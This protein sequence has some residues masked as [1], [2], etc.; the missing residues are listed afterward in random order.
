MTRTATTLIAAVKKGDLSGTRRLLRNGQD[1]NSRDADSLT[2]LM[3]AARKGHVKVLETLLAAGA[4]PK[5]RDPVGQTA[6]HHAVAFKHRHVIHALVQGGA[7]VNA[8]DKDDCTPFELATLADEYEIAKE[9]SV[10]GAKDDPPDPGIISVGRSPDSAKHSPVEETI[11]LL[12]LRLAEL[13]EHNAWGQRGHLR[14]VFHV[15]DSRKKTG[16]DGIHKGPFSK[17]KRILEVRVA[18]P[19]ALTK[20]RPIE[21]L[22]D[23]IGKAVD[24]AEPTFKRAKVK[25]PAPAIREHLDAIGVM[26]NWEFPDFQS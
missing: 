6:L 20:K 17:K 2:M 13:P 7:D 25:F 11:D 14:V 16:F 5:A 4:D 26:K 1:P 15:H 24:L 12:S 9:L 3:W 23:C 8:K 10:L 18:V 19:K 21:F 22:L